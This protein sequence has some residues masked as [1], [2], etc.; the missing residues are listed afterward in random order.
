MFVFTLFYEIHDTYHIK[1]FKEK[2]ESL[3]SRILILEGAGVQLSKIG[4]VKGNSGADS[5]EFRGGSLAMG[6]YRQS[7]PPPPANLG[8]LV[9]SNY[10][11]LQNLYPP[12]HVNQ[13]NFSRGVGGEC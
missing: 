6:S 7:P 10:P 13:G 8:Y 1:C 9:L 3:L 4:A 12:L 5:P 11:R 2:L